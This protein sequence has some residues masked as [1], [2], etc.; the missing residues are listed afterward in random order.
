MRL[1]VRY[2]YRHLKRILTQ[3]TTTSRRLKEQQQR[4]PPPQQPRSLIRLKPR[5]RT[6][7]ATR[8][9]PPPPPLTLARISAINKRS[10]QAIEKQKDLPWPTELSSSFAISVRP[11]RW[12]GMRERLGPWIKNVKLWNGTNGSTVNTGK[13]LQTG[14]LSRSSVLKRGQLGCYDS[15]VRIWQHIVKTKAPMTLIMEDDANLRYTENHAKKMRMILDQVQK[16]KGWHLLY[17]GRC[18]GKTKGALTPLLKSPLGC[19]CLFAYILSL[20]GAKM[21]LKYAHPY[22]IAVD[23]MVSN[24]HDKGKLIAACASPSLFTTVPLQSDT[25]GII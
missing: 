15:H 10:G 3:T 25:E 2:R 7:T 22:R 16:I 9:R 12:Q 8:Y 13:W 5:S 18:T 4:Q 20:E 11:Q 23:V 24:A 19:G 17:L 1:L 14:K 6:R 21:L